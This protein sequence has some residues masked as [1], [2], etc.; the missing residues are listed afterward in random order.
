MEK[1]FLFWYLRGTVSS[2]LP[3]RP[4]GN[5]SFRGLRL[6]PQ[7]RRKAETPQRTAAEQTSFSL[8]FRSPNHR[9]PRNAAEE[10]MSIADN[11]LCKQQKQPNPAAR[12]PML[13]SL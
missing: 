7:T 11:S 3:R 1:F 4:R 9:R 12:P 2:N 13:C 10:E 6:W 8:F 5:D